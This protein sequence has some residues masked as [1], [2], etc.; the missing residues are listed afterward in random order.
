[1]LHCWAALL[2]IR[3]TVVQAFGSGFQFRDD[4]EVFKLCGHRRFSVVRFL[5]LLQTLLFFEKNVGGYMFRQRKIIKIN[6]KSFDCVIALIFN[7]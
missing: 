1:M 5:Y 2:F 4:N 7:I 3:Y 6:D